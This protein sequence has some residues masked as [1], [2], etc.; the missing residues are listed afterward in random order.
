M[1]ILDGHKMVLVEGVPAIF[2][3]QNIQLFEGTFPPPPYLA[4][5]MN[6]MVDYTASQ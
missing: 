2:S 5:P 3:W 1:N 4:N 6:C